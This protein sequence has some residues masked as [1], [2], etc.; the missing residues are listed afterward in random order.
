[1]PFSLWFRLPLFSAWHI[2]VPHGMGSIHPFTYEFHDICLHT[3]NSQKIK[4]VP[5]FPLKMKPLIKSYRSLSIPA[6]SA[7]CTMLGTKLE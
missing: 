4:I 7:I 1:M 2:N 3:T 6:S 5:T